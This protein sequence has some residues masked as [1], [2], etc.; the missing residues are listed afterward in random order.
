MSTRCWIGAETEVGIRAVHVQ[1]DGDSYA[2]AIPELVAEHGID[3]VVSTLL[4]TAHPWLGFAWTPMPEHVHLYSSD[5]Y[6]IVP[7]GFGVKFNVNEQ[8]PEYYTP[9]DQIPWD[10]EYVYVI[11]ADGTLSWCHKGVT[12]RGR[13]WRTQEWKQGAL[14]PQ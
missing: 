5:R 12:K 14:T 3:K 11:L 1:C 9:K 7:G 8:A 4:K 10:I 2:E 13:T 6:E